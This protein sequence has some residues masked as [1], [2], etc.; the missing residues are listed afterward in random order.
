MS[1][2][3]TKPIDD[4]GQAFP[5]LGNVGYNTPWQVEGGMT[6]REEYASRAM[7]GIM[8]GYWSNPEASGWGPKDFALEAV[9]CADALIAE[10]KGEAR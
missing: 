5:M 10:L 4:G 6:K 3:T 9:A 8:A 2:D 1:E 7:A